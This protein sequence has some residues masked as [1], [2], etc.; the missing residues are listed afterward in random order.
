[1]NRPYIIAID[2]IAGGGKSTLSGA[3]NA[4]LSSSARYCFDDYDEPDIHPTDF[5]DWWQRGADIAAFD[6]PTLYQMV[7]R[8]IEK[9]DV[10]HL[11]LDMPF[12]RQHGRFLH[13]IDLS[14]FIDTPLD[15]ALARRIL[16]DHDDLTSVRHEMKEYLSKVRALYTD[17]FQMSKTCDLVLDGTWPVE[18]RKDTVLKHIKH[19]G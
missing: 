18:S 17:H 8:H 2:A 12:G 3:V 11:V 15:I 1:M 13:L 14:V 4:A 5:Y 7:S 9:K 16:R 6:C 10:G 19:A